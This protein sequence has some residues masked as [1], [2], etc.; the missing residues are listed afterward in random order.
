MIPTFGLEIVARKLGNL[1]AN[2]RR[3]G[4]REAWRLYRYRL[5]ERYDDWRLGIRTTGLV[6][7]RE[8]GHDAHCQPYEAIH[9]R[10]LDVIMDYF[11]PSP[12]L[13]VLLDYGSG[14]GR[15]VIVAAMRPFKRVIGVELSSTLNQIAL[16]NISRARS[17]LV[18]PDVQIVTIDATQYHVPTEV[19]SVF[20]FNPFNGPVLEAVQQQIRDSLRQKPRPLRLVYMHPAHQVNTF[21]QCDWLQRDRQ[22][23]TADWDDVKMVGYQAV[24]ERM[25]ASTP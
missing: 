7:P 5:S 6:T 18:C 23:P 20:L 10:C 11:D 16:D 19:T 22:L 1:A 14:M 25:R 2:I 4:P 21:D 13:D 9:Y 12:E 8:L 24:V 3:L 17:K 15:A